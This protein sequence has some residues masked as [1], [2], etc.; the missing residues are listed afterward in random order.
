MFYHQISTLGLYYSYMSEEIHFQ[1]S[2]PPINDITTLGIGRTSS[3]VT[4]YTTTSYSFSAHLTHK[5]IPNVDI[6]NVTVC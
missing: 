4:T 6:P 3:S 1:Q 2:I 5:V